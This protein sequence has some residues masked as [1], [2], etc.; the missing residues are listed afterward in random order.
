MVS[1]SLRP[2]CCKPNG[3]DNVFLRPPQK[4]ISAIRGAGSKSFLKE[5]VTLGQNN[6]VVAISIQP[7]KE[8]GA[9]ERGV[10]SVVE[11]L[12]QL[13]SSYTAHEKSSVFKGVRSSVISDL[14]QTLQT[15][16][17]SLE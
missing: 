2:G 6:D 15:C 1:S 13:L 14:R 7:V 12:I 3:N 11:G 17:L 16:F 10:R 9:A 5:G 4:S 8:H